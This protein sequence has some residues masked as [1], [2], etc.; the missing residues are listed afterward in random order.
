MKRE[1][2]PD[3]RQRFT[4]EEVARVFVGAARRFAIRALLDDALGAG[5]VC[6]FRAIELGGGEPEG[7]DAFELGHER[8]E[9][10][11]D[12]VARHQRLQRSLRHASSAP[13]TGR[14]RRR[15]AGTAACRLCESSSR[16]SPSI[17]ENNWSFMIVAIAADRSLIAGRSQVAEAHD[18]VRALLIGDDG[19]ARARMLGHVEHGTPPLRIWID[20]RREVLPDHGGDGVPSTS[21]T[22]ITAIRSG[23]YQSR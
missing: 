15:P 4:L 9:A 10:T 6:L 18:G 12:A 8:I 7:H 23:R 3:R 22:T 16:R 20:E 13:G 14:G 2:L 1:L 5:H 19:V 17:C 21:P 11:R